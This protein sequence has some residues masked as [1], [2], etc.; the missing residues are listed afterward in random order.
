[1]NSEPQQSIF[2]HLG[3]GVSKAFL[4]VVLPAWFVFLNFQK[5][6][7]WYFGVSDLPVFEEMH[8]HFQTGLELVGSDFRGEKSRF[9]LPDSADVENDFFKEKTPRPA[10]HKKYWHRPTIENELLEALPAQKHAAVL[11]FLNYIEQHRDLAADEMRHARIPA[12]ITLAQGLLESDA[13]RSFLA[14]NAHN[15]FGIKCRQISGGRGGNHLK[16]QNFDTHS[17][18]VDCVQR[19]DD[20]VWDRFEVY[21]ASDASFRRHSLLLLGSRYNWMIRRYPVGE[22]CRPPRPIYGQNEVPYYAGWALGLKDSGYATSKRYAEKLTLI[23]VTYS[24]C[25]IVYVFVSL[26]GIYSAL[27]KKRG[28]INSALQD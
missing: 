25:K 12:S 13:G 20:N 16:N 11:A 19:T 5:L 17:L 15:H 27:K 3:R 4:V 7:R 23:I 28:G 8:S 2:H 26:G 22:N 24:L 21:P 1:M 10:S 6:E 9:F 18:A 14:K